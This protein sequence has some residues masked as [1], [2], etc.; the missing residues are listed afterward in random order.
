M[1]TSR[2][3]LLNDQ[4]RRTFTGGRVVMSA[5]IAALPDDAKAEVFVNVREFAEFNDDNDP[6]GEHDFGRF[7]LNGQQFFWKI[8][9]YDERL[10]WG[11]DD[12]ADLEK[13][14]RVLTIMF[15]EEY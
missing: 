6:H 7:E 4:L 14:T 1:N 3:R 10:K 2:I 5:G 15:R 13:T 11:S 9:Y 8:D 12:P